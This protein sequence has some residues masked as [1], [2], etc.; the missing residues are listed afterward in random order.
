MRKLA[1]CFCLTALC[2]F[3][4][5]AQ[6]RG[7]LSKNFLKGKHIIHTHPN[8]SAFK[9]KGNIPA[10]HGFPA[11]VD[12]ITNFTG[13]FQAQGIYPISATAG[14]NRDIWEYSMVGHPPDQG[15]TTVINAPVVPVT[16][17][18]RNPDGS[19]AFVTTTVQNCPTCTPAQLGQSIRLIS[20]PDPFSS[21]FMN[22]PQFQN[23]DYTS[24]P[25][26]TQIMD[27]EQR[28]E[29]GNHAR[30]DWHTLL[31]A[32]LQAGQT[33]VLT[34][35]ASPAPPSY[36]FA[37]N[38]DGTCCAFVLVSDPVFTSQ[39][40]PPSTPDLSTVI[41]AAEVQGEITTKD[42]STFLFPNT[43]LFENSDPNQCCVLGF[44]A[45]DFELG[46]PSNG[47]QLRFYIMNYSSWTSPGLFDNPATCAPDNCFEDV[48]AV[49]HELAET[50]NDPFV[51]FD[52]IHNVTPFWLN[53]AGQCQDVMEDG[54]VIEDLPNPTVPI[55][56]NG[57]TYHPQTVALLPWFEF[58][59][60]SSAIHGAYSYPNETALTALSAP[61]P[62]NCG[63]Q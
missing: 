23:A 6:T 59:G 62:L 30:Q 11:G 37:L 1:F 32:K 15:G 40:F 18:M 29:F 48:T 58:Q 56:I 61:Q 19:P 63:G 39:L 41:G 17:D 38:G 22:G 45:F 9:V 7:Q 16:V 47:N 25:V 42:I 27:A 8:P 2:S 34:Q 13:H 53:P 49:S 4:A 28:A 20:R 31:S 33:M 26:P 10:P 44:H 52:G 3:T 50:F 43:Y 46:I 51:A 21:L 60:N 24:S 5:L 12:T 35:T 36:F 54:D 57:F 14:V 55:T